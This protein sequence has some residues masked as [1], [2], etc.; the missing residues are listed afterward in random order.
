[1]QRAKI[2]SKKWKLK[3]KHLFV[4]ICHLDS[5]DLYFDFLP[6]SSISTKGEDA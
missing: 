2:Q 3:M 4:L 6:F 5:Y 1:M